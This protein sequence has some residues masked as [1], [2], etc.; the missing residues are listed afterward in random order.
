M[1]NMNRRQYD[2]QVAI[3]TLCAAHEEI[4][5]GNPVA[6][7]MLAQLNASTSHV[8]AAFA[9]H[10]AG[11]AARK[12]GT[13]ARR[14]ARK[15]LRKSLRAIARTGPVVA[16]EAGTEAG[17]EMPKGCSDRQ[18]IAIAE[19]FARRATPL[20]SKFLAHKLPADVIANLPEQM[21]ALDR[22]M[23]RQSEGRSAHKVARRAIDAELRSGSEAMDALERIYMNAVGD[24]VTAVGNWKEARRVGPSRTVEPAAETPSEPPAGAPAPPASTRVA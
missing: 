19:D 17:F 12:N 7:K 22:A 1:K 13:N 20:A 10:E 3:R 24:D 2:A 8:A 15:A 5:G 11:R 21:A 4:F 16:L 14:G 9:A 18:L 23:A 6:E